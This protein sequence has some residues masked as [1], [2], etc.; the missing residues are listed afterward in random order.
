V[1]PKENAAPTAS[2]EIHSNEEIQMRRLATHTTAL[3][4]ALTLATTGLFAALDDQKTRISISQPLEIPGKILTPGDYTLELAGGATNNSAVVVR[5]ADNQTVA[6]LMTIETKRDDAVGQS[7]FT[8]Y[9]TPGDEAPALRS[10]FYPGRSYGHEFIYPESRSKE[11]ARDSRR[12]VPS[13]SDADYKKMET[14]HQ[15]EWLILAIGPDGKSS[16]IDEAR[17]YNYDVDAKTWRSDE[18]MRSQRVETRVERQ[19][20]KEIVTLPFYPGFPI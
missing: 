11:L 16:N 19:I 3:L 20:R 2:K 10:W 15:D 14:G 1:K 12:F 7:E 13:M 17:S 18:M 4:A 6:S 8:F 5:T 9:E